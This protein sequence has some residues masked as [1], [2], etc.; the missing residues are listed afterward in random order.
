[1][2][3]LIR[4]L[5]RRKTRDSEGLFL[6]E[7]VR[8]VED[9]LDSPLSIRL[10]LCAS[11][12][13]D[14]PRGAELVRRLAERTELHRVSDA[15]LAALAATD[16]PQGV[17]AVAEAPHH[18]LESI[19]IDD[20]ALVLVLDA[21]QDPGNV[22]TMLRTADAL[23]ARFVAALPG[24]VDAWN[25]KVVRSAAGASFRT[26]VIATELAG[27]TD[28]L[29]A[30]D[31]TIFAADMIGQAVDTVPVPARAALIVGNEG[32]GLSGAARA[33]ADV[34]VSVPIRGNAESLNVAVAAGILLF[35]LSRGAET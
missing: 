20:A 23:G 35:A 33:A 18:S 15:A 29:H 9:L 12:L 32:A 3:R 17:L 34:A 19:E 26:P 22:G 1:M 10:A 6:A 28:W 11:S 4:S 5:H 25:P 16:T 30:R 24:T 14:S 8:V 31:F 2:Q 13:E 7:G 21:V 27:L